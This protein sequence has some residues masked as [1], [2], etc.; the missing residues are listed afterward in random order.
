MGGIDGENFRKNAKENPKKFSPRTKV[1]LAEH[2]AKTK[3]LWKINQ[4]V[5]CENSQLERATGY[6]SS[7]RSVMRA[8]DVKNLF[9]FYLHKIYFKL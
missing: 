6:A 1:L 9:F 8:D 7:V 3:I 4:Y 5:I 2:Q